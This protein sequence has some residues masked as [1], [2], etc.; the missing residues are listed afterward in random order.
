VA[1]YRVDPRFLRQTAPDG[2][3]LAY[4]THGERDTGHLTL[5][6]DADHEVTG[7]E[8]AYDRFLGNGELFVTWD[9]LD[10]MRQ[11]EI[12]AGGRGG[13][14]GPGHTMSPLVRARRLSASDL[15]RLL[16]YVER[17]AGPLASSHRETIIDVLRKALDASPA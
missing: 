6:L 12:D 10:G 7:F 9:R 8:L 17:S 15:N 14:F 5:Y 4:V 3:T 16:V 2:V 13:G 11:S 1:W